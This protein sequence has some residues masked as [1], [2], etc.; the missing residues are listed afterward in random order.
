MAYQIKRNAK[1]DPEGRLIM[2]FEVVDI[3][4]G[5]EHHSGERPLFDSRQKA[6]YWI[7]RHQPR[8]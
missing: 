8:S 5:Q 3:I 2:L 7:D 1:K 4:D 6:Q